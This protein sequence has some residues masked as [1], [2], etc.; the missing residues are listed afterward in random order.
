MSQHGPLPGSNRLN[1]NIILLTLQIHPSMKT[2]L[3]LTAFLAGSACSVHAQTRFVGDDYL[4]YF[5]WHNSNSQLE[6]LFTPGS[7]LYAFGDE[8][9]MYRYPD[10]HS[11]ILA[12]LKDGQSLRNRSDYRKV[13]HIPDGEVNGYRDIW[14]KVS[15]D[16]GV[17]GYVF[18]S[19]IAKG[20]RWADLT[21]D[22]QQELILLG[23]SPSPRRNFSDIRAEIRILQDDQLLYNTSVPGL[24]VFEECGSSPML[25]ILKDEPYRGGIIVEA[26]TMTVG[27]LTG[28]ERAFFFW[29]GRQLE[30]VF[31]AEYTVDKE[32]DRHAFQVRD[33]EA[34]RTMICNYKQ[35]D[36]SFNP[37]WEC[38]EIQT[39]APASPDVKKAVVRA[40]AR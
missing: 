7:Q 30:S 4:R 24:C 8:V 14:F 1:S 35:Q 10:Q 25:R 11:E 17:C 38:R 19:Q 32:Y 6:K 21:G 27:C 9:K 2:T 39:K 5:E 28:I 37:V 15:T 13:Q 33:P 26:S 40:R 12:K 29:N 22:Q 34:V 18:G 20:W 16:Q 31:H 3:L 36:E 23:V